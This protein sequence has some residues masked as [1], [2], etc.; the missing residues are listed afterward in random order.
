MTSDQMFDDSLTHCPSCCTQ[1]KAS[2]LRQEL[3]QKRILSNAKKNAKEEAEEEALKKLEIST[4]ASTVPIDDS[5]AVADSA[6]KTETEASVLATVEAETKSE[7]QLAVKSGEDRAEESSAKERERDMD[8]ELFG[9]ELNEMFSKITPASV[10]QSLQLNANCFIEGFE[11]DVDPAVALKDEETARGLAD[12]LFKQVLVSL[13]EQVQYYH[14]SL[15]TLSSCTVPP[16]S[17]TDCTLFS[18]AV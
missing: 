9:S 13:T 16:Y 15:Y 4:A 10:A 5:S 17:L 2:L 18:I 12:F 1:H 8:D 11:C 3:I 7:V 14:F 6:V